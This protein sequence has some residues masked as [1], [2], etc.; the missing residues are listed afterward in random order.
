[1]GVS[2]MQK[3]DSWPFI[4]LINQPL[5][6]RRPAWWR[7][8]PAAAC[9]ASLSEGVRIEDAFPDPTGTLKTA[10][11]DFRRFLSVVGIA[12][13]AA[14]PYAI[15]I[16]QADTGC[17]E[18]YRI[19]VTD[20]C[21]A[22][23]AGD[24]EGIRR[25]LVEIEEQIL[26]TGAPALPLGVTS[27]SPVIRTRLSRC[28]FGPI[29]RPPMYRDELEDDVNYYPDE[30]LNRLAHEGVNALWLTI[31][32][33]DTVP[34]D[35]LPGFGRRADAHIPKLRRTVEQCARYGIRV[36][37]FFIEPT[38]FIDERDNFRYLDIRRYEKD[39][40]ELLGNRQ[41]N[42]T[43]FCPSSDLA[44]RFLYGAANTLFTLVPGLGGMID[45]SVGERFT[46]CASGR[47]ANNNCPRCAPREP[48]DVLADVL[49]SF[50]DGMRDA[51][52]DAQLI[53]WP[54]SQYIVWG[55]DLTVR[56]AGRV[57]GGVALQHNFES[58]GTPEQLGRTRTV[59]DYWLSYAGPS[60]LY[61]A[62]AAAARGRGTRIFAKLQVG[63]SHEV[64]T[65]T[66]VPVPGI[67]YE[68]YRAMHE[69]GVSGAMQGWYFGNYPSLMTRAAGRLSFGPL[70]ASREEFLLEYARIDWGPWAK[71]VAAAWERFRSA[72][73]QY[74]HYHVFGYYAP[75]H[76][77]PVWPLYLTPVNM[78]L[79]PN[80]K[81]MP[82]FPRCGDRVGEC[83]HDSHTFEETLL[84]C[85]RIKE[86]WNQ[87]LAMLEPVAEA[88]AGDPVRMREIGCARAL[89]LLFESGY[90]ILRFYYLREK[91]AD[92]TGA[93]ALA[94]LAEMR[95]IVRRE[96]EISR[97]LIGCCAL[98]P[99]LGFNSEHEGYR[100]DAARLEERIRG[101]AALLRED[102]P[103]VERRVSEGLLP[104][105]WYTGQEPDREAYR[106]AR[107]A[108]EDGLFT[109]WD[110]IRPEAYLTDAAGKK[111]AR[112][113]ACH[114]GAHLY[115]RIDMK[116]PLPVTIQLFPVRLWPDRTYVAEPGD[117]CAQLQRWFGEGEVP[118]ADRLPMRSERDGEGYAV[119]LRVDIDELGRHPETR[120]NPLR[121]NLKLGSE[122]PAAW[123]HR[124]SIAHRLAQSPVNPDDYGWFSFG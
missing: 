24:T 13:T 104:F 101:L 124:E 68:K 37:V 73:E 21:C 55:P 28:F 118:Y 3:P 76:D 81:Y 90:D 49:T 115:I 1:M 59:Q 70:P 78:P 83:M 60:D 123:V 44:R 51:S 18:S 66:H 100:F 16:G 43:A 25:G 96:M 106:C 116:E 38:A 46:H 63:C 32:F 33:R 112:F 110:Q 105:P 85:A 45:I 95:D 84:L 62:C 27:R 80:W 75:M 39:F 89:G 36:Y 82:E 77:G 122:N 48:W 56:A 88:F 102:F 53:S 7:Q 26:K 107:V 47:C 87:G 41:G 57:P 121:I 67:L 61:R 29:K 11:D 52:P 108:A 9:E 71:E 86:R 14:S 4:E 113:R 42:L 92:T 19:T 17:S 23:E 31:T 111:T 8:R 58:G 12:E 94:C 120:L 97:Q 114:N 79:I 91:L 64:A 30:Y 2:A 103:D 40:P 69:L 10:R 15:R 5:H 34:S 98:D 6:E 117:D 35:V 119:T 50:R 72:Y 109:A 22:L 99:A 65:V 93:P 74:P 54:Y 20:R